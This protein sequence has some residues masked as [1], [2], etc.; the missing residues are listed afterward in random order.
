MKM[1]YNTLILVMLIV[2]TP[3]LGFSAP[4]QIICVTKAGGKVS[5][6]K[7]HCSKS[8]VPLSGNY[9]N[10]L[11]KS[12]TEVTVASI[13]PKQGE[14]GPQGKTGPQGSVGPQGPVG[15]VGPQ[16]LPGNPGP[17]IY[18]PIPSGKTVYGV[19]GGDFEKAGTFWVYSSLPAPS[20][21][22][23]S[24]IDVIIASNQKIVDYSA[25]FCGGGNKC[26]NQEEQSQ[27]VANICLGSA[28]QP[29]APKGKVCIYT[30]EIFN[31]FDLIAVAAP[32]DSS[33]FG[34]AVNWASAKE[35]SSDTYFEGVWA[36]QAP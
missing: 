24:N 30:T 23:L 15:P 33:R 18:E 28:A 13:N 27:S 10:S 36:F 26:L 34:F 31:A 14:P 5:I 8:E 19:I 22:A 25:Q 21:S 32:F 6:K 17:S 4:K 12:T 35:V 29:T 1:F 11:I 16:G 9:I 3:S 20:Q 7:K 2:I